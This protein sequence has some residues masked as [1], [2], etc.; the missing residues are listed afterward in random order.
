MFQDHSHLLVDPYSH[1]VLELHIF[2]AEN[3]NIL[4]GIFINPTTQ[5]IYPIISGVPIFIKNRIPEQFFIK[6]KVGILAH[7]RDEAF[8]LK[9]LSQEKKVFSFSKE[10]EIAHKDNAQK[11]WGIPLDERLQIHYTDTDTSESDQEG[12]LILDVGCGNGIL[13]KALGEKEAK[14][15]AIDYSTSVWNA[16]ER[17]S[18]KNVCYIQADLHFLPFKNETFDIVYSNGVLHHTPNTENAFNQVASKVKTG[19]KYY[20]WL[21]KRGDT[22]KFNTFLYV[23]DGL[24][25]VVNKLPDSI[26]ENII[27]FLVRLKIRF[28]KSKGRH[29][30]TDVIRTDW[31][32]TLT[33]TYKYYH[34]FEEAEKWFSKNKF[35]NIRQTHKNIYG[36]G[37]LGEKAF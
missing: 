21:Y 25:F 15:Y 17:M 28:N 22:L 37:I 31:Y 5:I 16:Q 11:I 19:G 3:D 1:E 35:T 8:V 33:P 26:Q 32:D 14:V 2:Q 36:I 27:E 7:I 20:V 13:C 18:H 9:Q 12:K 34:T 4:D 29:E 6:H 23:T 10:W 24:R 30:D